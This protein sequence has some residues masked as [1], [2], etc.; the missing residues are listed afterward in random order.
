MNK[1]TLFFVLLPFISCSQEINKL[2]DN[3]EKTGLWVK[4]YINGNIR[5]KGQFKDGRAQGIFLYYYESGELRAE[6]NF[7]HNGE[8]AAAHF[9]YKD[10]HLQSSGLY[11]GPVVNCILAPGLGSSDS[12]AR[13]KLNPC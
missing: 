9:F 10:G 1:L 11:V 13:T 7:F 4:K 2:D 3:G 8:A 6:K 5:Y 12:P